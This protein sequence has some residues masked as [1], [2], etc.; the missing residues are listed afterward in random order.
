MNGAPAAPAE[1]VS[2]LVA[3]NISDFRA[4]VSESFVPYRSRPPDPTTSEGSSAE[5]P[6][7][8]CM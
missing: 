4:A 6:S 5:P 1:L 2:T 8:R 3:R 7:T